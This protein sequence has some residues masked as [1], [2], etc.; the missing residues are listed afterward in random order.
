MLGIKYLVAGLKK[1]KM[2]MVKPFAVMV[3]REINRNDGILKYR[4]ITTD[5]N[6]LERTLR[7]KLCKLQ[8]GNPL[9][10]L[11]EAKLLDDWSPEQ[12]AG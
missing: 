2:K 5:K 7:Q 11:V 12:I 8:K 4:V 9:S 10:K 3:N 6:A 1:K